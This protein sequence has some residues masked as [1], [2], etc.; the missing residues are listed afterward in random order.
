MSNLTHSFIQFINFNY[1]CQIII[2]FYTWQLSIRLCHQKD[3]CDTGSILERGQGHGG[4]CGAVHLLQWTFLMH[5]PDI[6]STA[7]T[8]GDIIPVTWPVLLC[9]SFSATTTNF[10]DTRPDLMATTLDSFLHL[11]QM[12]CQSNNK[13]DAYKELEESTRVSHHI[14]SNTKHHAGKHKHTTHIQSW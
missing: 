3:P 13:L 9:Q 11:P 14:D 8:A 1:L 12:K 2:L 4:Q 5:S 10:L 7:V 6:C